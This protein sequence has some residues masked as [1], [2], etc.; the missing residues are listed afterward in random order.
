MHTMPHSCRNQLVCAIGND[1]VS[2][3]RATE[4]GRHTFPL[5]CV[6]PA[7]SGV[8]A[9]RRRHRD[10]TATRRGGAARVQQP[11]KPKARKADAKP[12]SARATPRVPKTKRAKV[13]SDGPDGSAPAPKAKRT[14]RAK[15]TR[16]KSAR[17][18]ASGSSATLRDDLLLMLQTAQVNE[19]VRP[20]LLSRVMSRVRVSHAVVSSLL[21]T[22]LLHLVRP[23]V[24]SIFR[25]HSRV[26]TAVY[27][28]VP[29]VTSPPPLYTSG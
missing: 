1:V 22:D 18:A 13:T 14:A 8:T 27:M 24:S 21:H 16:P 4:S 3:P 11:R 10:P 9:A 26:F 7:R 12:R 6:R 15:A 23:S 17:S 29:V 28:S 2:L 25:G 5:N 20:H 19:A